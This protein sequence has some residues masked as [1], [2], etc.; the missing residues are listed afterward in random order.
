MMIVLKLAVHRLSANATSIS[1]H[2]AVS[3]ET[4]ANLIARGGGAVGAAD[5]ASSL[6]NVGLEIRK[7]DS[8]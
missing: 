2:Q 8:L 3:S 1:S 6:A 4:Q 5:A 7:I